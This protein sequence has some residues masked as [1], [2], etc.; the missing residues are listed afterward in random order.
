MNET[1]GYGNAQYQLAIKPSSLLWPIVI[2]HI[3][4]A[5]HLVPVFV[6]HRAIPRPA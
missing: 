5:K 6:Y 2:V 1:A 3:I 4:V